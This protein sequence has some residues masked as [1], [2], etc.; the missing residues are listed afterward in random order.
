[1]WG[2]LHTGAWQLDNLQ[3]VQMASQEV[4]GIMVAVML[5]QQG[6]M[7]EVSVWELEVEGAMREMARWV[8][9]EELDL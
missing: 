6:A 1:M 7:Q 2:L 3:G 8:D 5:L 4:S 9:S